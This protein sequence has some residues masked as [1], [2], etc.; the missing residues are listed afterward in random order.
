MN[1]KLQYVIAFMTISNNLEG[2]NVVIAHRMLR[3]EYGVTREEWRSLT[4]EMIREGKIA[5]AR[6]AAITDRLKER[7]EDQE[8][9]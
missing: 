5:V 7:S 9:I 4:R 3:E 6:I 2:E 8:V 1:W